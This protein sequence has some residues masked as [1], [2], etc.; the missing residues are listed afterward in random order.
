MT[1]TQR[2]KIVLCIEE[3]AYMKHTIKKLSKTD[4]LH[5]MSNDSVTRIG[6]STQHIPSIIKTD[7]SILKIKNKTAFKVK[8]GSLA[9]NAQS[10]LNKHFLGQIPTNSA[11]IAYKKNKSYLDLFEPHLNNYYFLRLDI[12]SFFHNISKNLV[13]ETFNPY[14][15]D[16][17]FFEQKQ[18]LIDVFINLVMFK[19]DDSVQDDK[20]K[21]KHIL[22]IGFKT[23]PAISNIIFRKYDL[24]IQEFCSKNNIIYTRYADNML[25]SS[26]KKYQ[27]INSDYF[28]NEISYIISGSNFKL[29]QNKTIRKSH[30]LSINGYVIDS[31][32]GNGKSLRLSNKK[33][34]IIAKL[35]NK[36]EKK[37]PHELILKKLFSISLDK[38]TLR[39]KGKGE[40]IKQY[41]KSQ[42][43]HKLTGYR[44]YLISIVKYHNKYQCIDDKYVEKYSEI[45]DKLKKQINVLN[46]SN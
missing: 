35:L 11:S 3:E 19:T 46:N 44:S 31:S 37:V 2:V 26:K 40:F 27:L 14:F 22:P 16:E 33:T 29:N 25:F 10:N 12:K 17:F 4:L 36:L 30:T 39:R 21:N 24:I 18:K 38:N 1:C 6:L 28:I 32:D 41:N 7:V 20:I 34:I 9:D 45:I 5:L 43:L 42:I 23:S 8:T 15:K 13:H